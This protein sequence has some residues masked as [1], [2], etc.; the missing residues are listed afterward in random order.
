[1]DASK[2]TSWSVKLTGLSSGFRKNIFL[3]WRDVFWKLKNP[4]WWDVFGR[5]QSRVLKGQINCTVFRILCGQNVETKKQKMILS[6]S[7]LISGI[8][9]P[10]KPG[11]AAHILA[12]QKTIG[13][14]LQLFSRKKCFLDNV[15][16]YM[17]G[18][19]WP[20]PKPRLEGSN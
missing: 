7:I 10:P 9:C 12:P 16:S 13:S 11:L 3:V 5:L 4:V 18:R 19:I 1:M 6:K 2:A 14:F 20:P 17:V 8:W 15:K